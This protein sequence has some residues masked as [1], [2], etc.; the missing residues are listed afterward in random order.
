MALAEDDDVVQTF[1][2]DGSDQSLSIRLLPWAGPSGDHFPMSML[3]T[4]RR[5]MSP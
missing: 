5:N 1:A 2:P 3:A 4:R